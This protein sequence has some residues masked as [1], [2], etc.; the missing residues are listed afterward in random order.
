MGMLP[1]DKWIHWYKILFS[2][3]DLAFMPSP[4]KSKGPPMRSVAH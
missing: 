2:T 3:D 4:C 1:H